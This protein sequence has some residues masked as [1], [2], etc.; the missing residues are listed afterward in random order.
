SRV[1]QFASP[2]FDA[3]VSEIFVALCSGAMLVMG[4]RSSMLPGLDLA[5]TLQK[6]AITTLTLPPTA[7]AALPVEPFE[8]LRTLVVA[9]EACPVALMRTW[10]S[11]RRF[12]NGYG[13]TEATVCAAMHAAQPGD[14]ALPI[15]RAGDNRRLYVLDP[16]GQPVPIGVPGELYIGGDGIARGYLNRPELTEEKFIPNPFGEGRLYR[17]GDLVRYLP[18]GN[19]DFLGRIDHQVKIR[20]FRIELGEIEETLSTHPSISEAVVVVREDQ[21]GDKRLVAYVVGDVDAS[22]LRVHLKAQLP[23]Y[24]VPSYFV[25]LEQLPLSPNGKVDRRALPEPERGVGARSGTYVAPRSP[26]EEVLAAIWGEVLDIEQVGIEDNFFDIGGHSL[27]LVAILSRLREKLGVDLSVRQILENPEIS[28]LSPVVEQAM[29]TQG[30]RATT[31]LGVQRRCVVP[32]SDGVGSPLFCFHPAGGDAMGYA[33]LAR[34]LS[35]RPIIGLQAPGLEGEREPFERVEDLAAYF[36][37]T[38]EL[39]HPTGPYYL[40]GW[41]YGGHVAFEVAQHLTR[42]GREVA[43]LT[44]VDADPDSRITAR[45]EVLKQID[46]SWQLLG[47]VAFYIEKLFGVRLPYSPE[48]W[49]HESDSEQIERFVRVLNGVD[50]PRARAFKPVHLRRLL[51]V[52]RANYRAALAYE[53]ERYSGPLNFIR[54]AESEHLLQSAFERWSEL[55]TSPLEPHIVPGDHRSWLAEPNVET[56]ARL[57]QELIDKA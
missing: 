57:I 8:A 15:G 48:D 37:E 19:L 47:S 30:A 27:L 44:I 55:S 43:M 40:L 7:L 26:V 45:E 22:E 21:P 20:G 42:K 10:A 50:D 17:T 53:H 28:L 38:L 39:V 56:A 11:G 29:V 18:D 1:L 41:S 35:G 13:P 33:V 34:K 54:A 51:A 52:Y 25:S 36:V 3:S 12:L 49:K 4:D 9:G 32:L 23:E 31:G 24:M 16:H 14:A 2:A 46:E 5:R 6:H